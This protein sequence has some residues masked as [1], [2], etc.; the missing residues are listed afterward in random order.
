MQQKNE[1]PDW[2]LWLYEKWVG[3][4]LVL[5]VF[6]L[7]VAGGAVYLDSRI[8]TIEDRLDFVPP[9]SYVS[10]DLKNYSAGNMALDKLP[11]RQ[12][13]YV[14]SY[15][16]IYYH[17]GAPFLLETTLSIRNIDLDQSVY[18]KSIE[19]YDTEGKRVKSFL[20]QTIKLAPLQTIEFLI[21][22]QDSS[23]GSG[24]N[25]LVEW[26]AESE[27]DR[28]LL[29]SVMVGTSGSRGIS[30]VGTGVEISP[31]GKQSLKTQ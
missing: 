29:E 16:H 6:T 23:G 26:L 20:D 22:E 28:P 8:A 27:I 19:Y 25:F 10:P 17:G 13:V 1:Y 21:R 24:A 15:S 11:I 30:F 12:F 2:F 4:F 3:L 18:L 9:S 5:G 31:P 14:P 7:I